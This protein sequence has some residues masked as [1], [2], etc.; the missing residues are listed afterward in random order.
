MDQIQEFMRRAGFQEQFVQKYEGVGL[1]DLLKDL[2]IE[3]TKGERF[4]VVILKC[5]AQIS[6]ASFTPDFVGVSVNRKIFGRFF[7]F[8][9]RI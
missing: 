3:W 7:Q 6:F 5:F 1:S 2:C 8:R 9:S 4:V